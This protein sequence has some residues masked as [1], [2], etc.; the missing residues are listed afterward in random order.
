VKLVK[1]A[2]IKTPVQKMIFA[3][4][5]AYAPAPPSTAPIQVVA[6]KEA[7]VLMPADAFF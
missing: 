5:T 1:V 2:M 7:A 3:T 4:M 6:S